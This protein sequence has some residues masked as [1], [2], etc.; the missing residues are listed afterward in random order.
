MVKKFPVCSVAYLLSVVG[1]ISLSIVACEKQSGNE[2]QDADDIRDQLDGPWYAMT[3]E[4]KAAV[5]KLAGDLNT[6]GE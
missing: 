1:L 2:S 6:V 4:E 3:E 5:N